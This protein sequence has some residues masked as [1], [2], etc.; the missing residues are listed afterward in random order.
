MKDHHVDRPDVELQRCRKLTGTNRSI[1]L[2]FQDPA[3]LR[4]GRF[5]TRSGDAV[6][7]TIFP[8]NSWSL[9]GACNHAHMLRR[10]GGSSEGDTPDPIPNSAVKPFSAY[11]TSSQDAG[12]SVAARSSKHMD[13]KLKTP[14]NKTL[15]T[16][17][18]RPC[19]RALGVSSV[20]RGGAAR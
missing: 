11:G 9:L 12:E 1:G 14:L 18:P 6:A 20:T 10:P 8:S 2:N 7:R 16:L 3:R 19:M 5:A 15:D 13:V 4:L 17:K